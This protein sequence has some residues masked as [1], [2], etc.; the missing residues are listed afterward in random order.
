MVVWADPG[1]FQRIQQSLDL[2]ENLKF[3]RKQKLVVVL[4]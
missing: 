4:N 3:W 1:C 2:W